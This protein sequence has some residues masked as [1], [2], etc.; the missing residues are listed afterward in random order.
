V[1][2]DRM[3]PRRIDRWVHKQGALPLWQSG[4]VEASPYI[5]QPV[6]SGQIR[7]YTAFSA[8]SAKRAAHWMCLGGL[9]VTCRLGPV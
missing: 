7:Y 5:P 9:D 6:A 4:S 3:L 8:S 1:C 2:H